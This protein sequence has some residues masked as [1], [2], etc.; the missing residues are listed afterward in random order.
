MCEMYMICERNVARMAEDSTEN[1]SF[2]YQQEN[3]GLR[4]VPCWD[5]GFE[6]HR[7]HG[8]LSLVNVVCC[9]VEF[10][11]FAIG[12]SVVQ[13]SPTVCVCVIECEQV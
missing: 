5:C 13:K 3:V 6:F 7:E 12:R 11:F 1:I 10:F 4:P 2:Y 9:Q 8:C